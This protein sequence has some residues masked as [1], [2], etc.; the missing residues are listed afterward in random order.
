MKVNETSVT[1]NSV[2]NNRMSEHT[3]LTSPRQRTV[4]NTVRPVPDVVITVWG[5]S[6][7]W[8]GYHPKHIELSAEI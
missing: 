7:W 5:C 4:A 6:W 1:V 3:V 2:R 8:T